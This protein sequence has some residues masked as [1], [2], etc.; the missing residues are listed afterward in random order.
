MFKQPPNV[1]LP[2]NEPTKLNF[3]LPVKSTDVVLLADFQIQTVT[4][5]V[6]A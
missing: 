5:A 2:C 3:A 1:F 4:D 6:R